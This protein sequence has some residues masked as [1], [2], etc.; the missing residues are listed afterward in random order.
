MQHHKSVSLP[1]HICG[2]AL[3]FLGFGISLIIGLY[4]GNPFVTLV[5]RATCVLMVFYI[6]GL[7]L[8][9]LGHKVVQENF[10][11]QAEELLAEAKAK[12]EADAQAKAEAEAA[13]RAQAG[14][15]T[16]T[17]TGTEPRVGA[18]GTATS[19]GSAA[20]AQQPL[21]GRAQNQSQEEPMAVAGP[22]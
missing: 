16:D 7:I 8:A 22:P 5:L 18:P 1:S 9:S 10:E 11:T 6:L 3:G 13:A 4:V 2:A 17:G 20:A 21:P 15:G 19:V 12:A 14:A